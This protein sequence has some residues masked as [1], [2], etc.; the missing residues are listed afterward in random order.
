MHRILII[1]FFKSQEVLFKI[2]FDIISI[3]GDENEF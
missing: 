1:C 2:I 3:D